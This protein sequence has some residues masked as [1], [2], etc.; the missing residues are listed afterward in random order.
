MK[1]MSFILLVAL[2]SFAASCNNDCDEKTSLD[3]NF[4]ATF[5]SDPLVLYQDYTTPNGHDFEI[6]IFNQL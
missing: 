3:L 6:R 5:G 4:K 2:L 1:K